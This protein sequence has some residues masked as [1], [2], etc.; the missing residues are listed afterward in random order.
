MLTQPRTARFRIGDRVCWTRA[1]ADPNKVHIP[2]TVIDVIPGDSAL[3][4]FTM[5]DVKFEFGTF[6]L[7]G[8]QIEPE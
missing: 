1:V 8:T 2:G 6:T 3:D 4:A 5:Y 7:Y